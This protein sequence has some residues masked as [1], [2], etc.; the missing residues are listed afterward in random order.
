M[1]MRGMDIRIPFGTAKRGRV[2]RVWGR[3]GSAPGGGC[4]AVG[5][6]G[7]LGRVEEGGLDLR[8]EVA[9]LAGEWGSEAVAADAVAV[10]DLDGEA[11]ESEFVVRPVVGAAGG[12]VEDL[13][14][15][16]VLIAGE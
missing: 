5:S 11:G 4:G 6:S 13:A 3:R 15:L 16:A 9:V 10:A 12:V 7:M 1:G 14:G 8:P 2:R